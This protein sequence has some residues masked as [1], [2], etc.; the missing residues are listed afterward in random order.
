MKALN[1][2]PSD[3]TPVMSVDLQ[4][5]KAAATAVNIISILLMA[6]MVVPVIFFVPLALLWH[7][8]LWGGY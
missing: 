8:V 1:V 3:Y 7:I 2:L 6:L 5:N 4:N